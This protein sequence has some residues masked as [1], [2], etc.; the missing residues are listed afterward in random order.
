MPGSTLKPRH[1]QL[2][3]LRTAYAWRASYPWAHHARISKVVSDLGD[4]EIAAT[5]L[6]LEAHPW[7]ALDRA[8]LRACDETRLHG[9]I[10]DDTWR[11]LARELGQREL[12]DVVFTI[13]QYALI[14]TALESLRVE[15]DE[16]FV[17]PAWAGDAGAPVLF[18]FSGLPGAGKSTLAQSLARETGAVYL[19]IDTIEQALR[20][21]CAVDVQGEGY[22]LAYRVA[23]DNL[24]LGSSVVA[25]SCNPI[26][27][28]RREWE[29]V[30]RDAGASYV[31]VEVV[32][33]DVEEH[34]R[35][36]ESRASDVPGLELP[37]WSDVLGREYHAWTS[38]RLVIDTAKR[39]AGDCRSELLR[40]LGPKGAYRAP[41]VGW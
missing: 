33:T 14:S 19:R 36:V 13:G 17:R 5:A 24:R 9:S 2:L 3:I 12:M 40:R 29:S 37:T 30:A 1:R 34:R 11:V 7:Q 20:D 32:C 23:A 6:D 21:L 16:G 26:E 35:R 8:L 22:R 27:L 28:T 31:N 15:L 41:R 4:D 18:I 38:E 25:D 10:G 39:A